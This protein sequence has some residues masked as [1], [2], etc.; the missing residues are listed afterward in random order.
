MTT[1]YWA[2]STDS[3]ALSHHGVLGMKWGVRRYRNADGSLTPAGKRH[4]QRVNRKYDRK[5]GHLERDKADLQRNSAGLLNRKGTRYKATSQHVQRAI[6]GLDSK[7]QRLEAKRKEEINRLSDSPHGAVS[8][9]DVRRG[10]A[11]GE[12]Y[13]AAR[14]LK[15]AKTAGTTLG[16]ATMYVSGTKAMKQGKT[17]KQIAQ[18]MLKTEL[19]TMAVGA[20]VGYAKGKHEVR[21]AERHY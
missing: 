7:K 9:H 13:V 16:I 17:G 8:R 4:E 19:K 15:G 5:I 21:E 1:N 18:A 3:S 11:L 14:M 6:K 2:V 20:L 10:M 12:N